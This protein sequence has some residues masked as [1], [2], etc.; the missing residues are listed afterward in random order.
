MKA[1]VQWLV[2]QARVL[3]MVLR[4][5]VG[6]MTDRIQNFA[7]TGRGRLKVQTSQQN[8]DE[9]QLSAR[10]N[11]VTGNTTCKGEFI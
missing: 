3:L 7:A 4:S 5:D 2:M 9:R 6:L 10:L 8:Y 11:N 1:S